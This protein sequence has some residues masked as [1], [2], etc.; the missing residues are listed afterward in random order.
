MWSARRAGIRLLRL[1]GWTAWSLLRHAAAVRWRA[2]PVYTEISLEHFRRWADGVCR[3]LGMELHV[4]GDPPSRGFLLA[5]NHT[6]YLD[7]FVL[8]ALAPVRFVAKAEVR[9]WPLVG[10]MAARARQLFVRRT[11]SRRLRETL[12]LVDEALRRGHN[13]CVFLEGTSTG[14]DRVGRFHSSFLAPAVAG[15][16]KVVPV[17]LRYIPSDPRVQVAEDVAYWKEHTFVP[18]L[19]RFLGLPPVRVRVRFGEPWDFRGLPRS[20]AADLLRG[21]VA[22]LAELPCRD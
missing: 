5:P 22:A 6:G 18:H 17:G 3:I 4:E 15:T 19:V 8:A 13:V 12:E 16:A 21:R 2:E 7:I 14:G 11:R 1:L 20:H 9:R 10:W